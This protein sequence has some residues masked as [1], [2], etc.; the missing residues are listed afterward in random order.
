MNEKAITNEYSVVVGMGATGLSI[1]QHLAKLGEQF[2]VFDTRPS[3]V[4]AETFHEYFPEAKLYFGQI[5]DEI[6]KNAKQICLSPGVSR[7]E[8]VV[9][10]ALE[11]GLPVVGDIELFIRA[12][13]KPVIGITGSNGKSTVTTL[14]GMAAEMS[15]VHTAVGGNIGIPALDLLEQN[16]EL[17]VLELS[18]FQLESTTRLNLDVACILNV[19][20]DHMDRYESIQEYVEAKKRIY[21][22]AKHIVFNFDDRL[23]RV[24][25]SGTCSTRSFSLEMTEAAA[26]DGDITLYVFDRETEN[27]TIVNQQV[28]MK[29]S[30]IK[31]KGTHNVANALALFA[32]ADAYGLQREACVR[33]LNEFSGLPHRTQW[34]AEIEGVTFIND[35]KA[36]NVGAAEAAIKGLASECNKLILIAGGDGKGA[37]FTS[38]GETIREYVKSAVLLG[39]DAQAIADAIGQIPN[40]VQIEMCE[41]L[42]SCVDKAKALAGAGDVVLLSPACASL[43]MFNNFQERGELFTTLVT[44]TENR[45]S[46]T[47]GVTR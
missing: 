17:V 40:D 21:N 18:S 35:S 26:N 20:P 6:I 25:A 33:A 43:D 42:E 24:A 46:E 32:I 3:S 38:L 23:T 39:K 5:D 4:L 45:E 15:G 27:L 29:K 47:R 2:C 28:L 16:A 9:S 34:V 36:T 7:E 22:G 31:V 11:N 44:K 14:V 30:E 1:A 37:D 10:L 12:N 19:S 41:T 8:R 13:T